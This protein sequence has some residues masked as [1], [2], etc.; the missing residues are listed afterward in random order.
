MRYGHLSALSDT[1]LLVWVLEALC[2]AQRRLVELDLVL[3]DQA[4]ALALEEGRAAV[5]CVLVVG[6]QL[7]RLRHGDAAA[8]GGSR[9]GVLLGGCGNVCMRGICPCILLG[10]PGSLDCADCVSATGKAGGT[11]RV[12]RVVLRA[13]RCLCKPKWRMYGWM[14][15]QLGGWG[16]SMRAERH[17]QCGKVRCGD[18][19]R[20]TGRGD[21]WWV[22]EGGAQSVRRC[23]ARRVGYGG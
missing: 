11:A 7:R 15:E 21:L 3:L 2:E 16:D 8:R 4:E 14:D 6:V 13:S 20:Q 18:L 19:R 1:H 5:D 12:M 17:A 10:L 9:L 23:G 22:V